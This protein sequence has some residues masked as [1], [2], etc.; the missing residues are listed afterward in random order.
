MITLAIPVYNMESLLGRCMDAM[1]SQ[2]SRDFEIVLVDDGSTDSSPGLCDGYA[3]AHPDLIRVVHKPNGGLSSAR[4]AGIDAA[5]GEFII[6]PD[7]DDWTEPQYVEHLLTLQREHHAD[8]VCTGYFVA[9]DEASVPGSPEAGVSVLSG[10][11]ARRGL[12]LH[13]V[14]SGFAWNKLYRLSIIREHDLRFLDDVGT[15]E[16]LDFA[17]RYLAHAKTVC[18]AP[19]LRTYHYYQRPGAATHS[20]YSPKKLGSIRTYEKILADTSDPELADAA[21]EEICV[22]AVNLLWAWEMGERTDRAG[23]KA[24]LGHI[25]RQLP[26]HLR[27]NR[28]GL[29]RKLQAITAA[30]S[31]KLFTR[32]KNAAQK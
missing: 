15:T 32:L 1:L 27:S 11:D 19:G 12:L 7:P 23:R 18:H 16:D 10:R 26:V 22:T 2:T 24:L 20:G 29:G 13:P 21:R 30:L 5:R 6:F 9:T 28:Y 17:Y 8:L 31:P 14:M 3:A 25:R 4:N